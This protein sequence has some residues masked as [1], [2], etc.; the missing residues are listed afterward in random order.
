VWSSKFGR[1]WSRVSHEEL[2]NTPNWFSNV[3]YRN[4][5]NAFLRGD[6]SHDCFAR[7]FSFLS[8][9]FERFLHVSYPAGYPSLWISTHS[10]I[11]WL[12]NTSSDPRPTRTTGG[13]WATPHGLPTIENEFA[14]HFSFILDF[15]EKVVLVLRV[16]ASLAGSN[17]EWLIRRFEVGNFPWV[18]TRKWENG[19]RTV[20]GQMDGMDGYRKETGSEAMD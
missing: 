18:H 14:T 8:C 17:R 10:Y 4:V 15:G 19:R 3:F 1:V 2:R 7:S 13:N 11:D 5:V 20:D 12:F 6:I 16:D 9:I